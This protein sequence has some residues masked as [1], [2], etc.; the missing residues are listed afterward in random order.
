MPLQDATRTRAVPS[1]LQCDTVCGMAVGL[2]EKSIASGGYMFSL[3]PIY[4][5]NCPPSVFKLLLCVIMMLP[6]F[7]STCEGYALASAFTLEITDTGAG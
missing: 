6:H 4:G 5:E 1:K 7:I 3:L 2:V